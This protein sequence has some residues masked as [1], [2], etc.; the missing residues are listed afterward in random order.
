MQTTTSPKTAIP[1]ALGITKWVVPLYGNRFSQPY[2]VILCSDG[3]VQQICRTRQPE[4][5]EGC[6]AQYVFFRRRKYLVVNDGSLY[7]PKLRLALPS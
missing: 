4:G 3:T 7:R 2:G 6:F 1:Q 5:G